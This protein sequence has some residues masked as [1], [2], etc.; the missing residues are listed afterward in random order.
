MTSPYTESLFCTEVPHWHEVPSYEE[1]AG[2]CHPAGGA[3]PSDSSATFRA[4]V[5]GSCSLR[6]AL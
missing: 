4:A 3:K 1:P 2:Q 5:I 6:I